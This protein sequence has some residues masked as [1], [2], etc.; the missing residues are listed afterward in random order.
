LEAELS[1]RGFE[2]SSIVNRYRLG[3]IS[4]K[5]AEKRLMQIVEEI[6]KLSDKLG[7]KK[8]TKL[9]NKEY[10]DE[11]LSDKYGKPRHGVKGRE[12]DAEGRDQQ[13]LLLLEKEEP[14][15]TKMGTIRKQREPAFRRS[16]KEAA[17]IRLR[18]PSPLHA[19]GELEVPKTKQRLIIVPPLKVPTEMQEVAM[20]LPMTSTLKMENVSQYKTPSLTATTTPTTS[21][22][23]TPTYAH[24]TVSKISDDLWRDVP[25]VPVYDTV[26]AP[27]PM[28]LPPMW[29]RLLPPGS[30][31]GDGREGA[32]KMQF[33][34]KQVLALA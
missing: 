13:Q 23:A 18:K 22:V 10:V 15:E 29:W 16:R 17:A 8:W 9:Y 3:E 6:E 25:T 27:L 2:F 5:E 1:R 33:G 4:R 34:R 20:P 32:Y 11:V 31:A 30:I 19:V 12:R 21:E 14:A 28:P 7:D 24:I 26:P